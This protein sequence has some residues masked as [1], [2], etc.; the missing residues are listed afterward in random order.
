MKSDATRV[1]FTLLIA[2][3]T[4]ALLRSC[5][6]PYA[7]RTQCQH[8]ALARGVSERSAADIALPT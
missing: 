1:V 7:Q 8:D 3:P 6:P 5:L 4:L 2:Q